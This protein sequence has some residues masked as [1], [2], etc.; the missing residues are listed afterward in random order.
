MGLLKTLKNVVVFRG[1]TLEENKGLSLM[2]VLQWR[3]FKRLLDA[4]T[5]I[6]IVIKESPNLELKTQFWD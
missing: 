5:Q 2:K 4:A 1:Y 3:D 6:W